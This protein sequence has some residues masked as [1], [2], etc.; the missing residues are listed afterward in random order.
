MKSSEA[1]VKDKLSAVMKEANFYKKRV[2]QLTMMSN[3]IF[4]YVAKHV[5]YML[6]KT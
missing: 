4:M 2:L 5:T 3:S 1:D 6:N